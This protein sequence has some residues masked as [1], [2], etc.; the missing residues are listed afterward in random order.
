M[1]SIRGKLVAYFGIITLLSSLFM[2]LIGASTNT[3]DINTIKNQLLKS[4][5]ENN[6]GLAMK[7]ANNFY[8]KLQQCNDTLCD[9]DGKPIEGRSEMVD[10]ILEDLGDRS[11][12]F[13]K[14][15]NDFKRIQTSVTADDDERAVGTFL[16]T[17]HN[18][19]ETV[20]KG[21]LY[22]GE[23]NILG[24]NYYTAY[25]PM[26][27]D[28]DNIIGILFVGIPTKSL[29]NIIKVHD[30]KIERV[31]ILIIILRVISLSALIALAST[32]LIGRNLT[33][34]IKNVAKEIE[35]MANYNL[36]GHNEALEA[37]C[38]RDDDLGNTARS[39]L[40]LHNNLRDLV[41]DINNTSKDM[42]GLA[43]KLSSQELK[44]LAE[45]LE[46]TA[47]KFEI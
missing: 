25:Q 14:V 5:V 30:E 41:G 44:D 12:I 11:T 47:G 33:S 27:D 43:D 8:G 16:G 2:G 40:S 39:V 17:N 34:P 4:H 26:K 46:K 29:D 35:Q 23:A 45:E 18:A 19:Y 37:L 1:K 6:V 22:V 9:K 36:T 28:N 13:V 7:Y 3:N 42:A 21:D 32:S 31:N 20:M 10:A 24:D 15:G 38:Q